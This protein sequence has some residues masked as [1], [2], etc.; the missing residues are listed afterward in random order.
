MPIDEL[1]PSGPVQVSVKLPADVHGRGGKMLVSGSSFRP[2]VASG[3]ATAN[4]PSVLDHE[5][6]V[7]E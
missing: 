7:L 4:I 2:A 5:V 6:I 3:W 1:I